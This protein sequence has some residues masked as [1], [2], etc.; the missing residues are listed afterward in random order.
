MNRQV[1]K[2]KGSDH[3]Q[4]DLSRTAESS[5][6]S[7]LSDHSDYEPSSENETDSIGSNN[8]GSEYD[9]RRYP[10]R[11]RYQRSIPGAIPWSAVQI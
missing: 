5:S 4:L 6:A 3:R 10:Q 11:V 7:E 9:R 2:V 8:S 1:K